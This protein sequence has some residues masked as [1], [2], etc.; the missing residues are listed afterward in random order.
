MRPT[1]RIATLLALA[2]SLVLFSSVGAFASPTV[3][4]MRPPIKLVDGW[5]RELD[6]TSVKRPLLM[7]YAG[8]DT[9]S[10]NLTLSSELAT[11]EVA[12]HYRRTIL[13]VAVADVSPYSHWPARGLVKNEL[14]KH[15]SLLGIVVYSDFTGQVGTTLGVTPGKSNVVLYESDGRVLF[16]CA[17]PVPAAERKVLLDL[18]RAHVGTP[19]GRS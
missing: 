8:K 7:V 16:S 9:S 3:G 11:L 17:G 2:F 10:Q 13:E 4:S 14:Q 15:S 18:I 1:G 19:P 6:L 5:D 12:I